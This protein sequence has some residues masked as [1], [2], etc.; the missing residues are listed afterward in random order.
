M[1]RELF[2]VE[3][4]HNVYAENGDLLF[5]IIGGSG[6]P[7]GVS[8]EQQNVPIG[9]LYV[10]S[11]TGELYQKIANAGAPSDY[12]LNGSSSATIGKWRNELVDAVTND[13]VSAGTIDYALNPFADDDGPLSASDFTV[14]HYVIG[15]ADGSPALFEITNISGD[16][17]TFAAAANPLVEEDTFISKYYLP[18]PAGQEN[19]ALVNYNGSVILKISDIDWEFATGINISSGYTSGNGSISSADSVESAIEKLDGNQQDIQSASGLTQ[20]DVDYG[21]FTGD[22]LADN[23]TSK[24]LFQRLEDLLDQLKGVQV[25]G[26][27]TSTAVDAVPHASVK[28]CKWLIEAFEEATPANRKALEVYALTDGTSVDDTVYARL[29]VGSNFNL[30]V[31]VAINGAN[32][33]LQAASSTA[34]VT[35]TARRIEVVKNT[36]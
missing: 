25:T 17:I 9:S 34:G 33:E 29:R 23:Q 31:S 7:D 3:L 19:R 24:D 14:G 20:G 10:R 16:D 6:A 15:D 21:A 35:V 4:G 22:L 8:G 36:L 18:D 5:S 32:M 11:G 28:A 2:G 12:E 30:T 27:T 13:V 1:S 26:V